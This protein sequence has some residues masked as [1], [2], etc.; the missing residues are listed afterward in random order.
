L[1]LPAERDLPILE[2]DSVVAGYGAMTILNGASF[3]VRR[4][5]ITTIIG[6]N[7]AGKSTIFKTVFGLLP[8]SAGRIRFDG[9]DTTNAS[10]R[11]L[12]ARRLAYIPQGR[13]IFSE[14]SV[15]HNLEFGTVAMPRGAD[16]DGLLTA[17]LERFPMLKRKANRQASTLSGGEQKLLEVARG[18]MISPKLLLIDEPSIGLSPVMTQEVFAILRELRADG[19]T[20]L[21]VEQNAR[22]ALEISDDGI[23]LELGRTRM[24]GTARA[25]LDDPAIGR[26]FLGGSLAESAAAQ[27]GAS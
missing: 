7:G 6:P 8:V 2:L 13:N 22:S 25:L 20:I 3:A 21:M 19:T 10:P 4:A 12:L 24:T 1:I 27:G 14:L 5:A 18:L 17:A 16:R 26:L 11:E 9:R 15:R 23:V